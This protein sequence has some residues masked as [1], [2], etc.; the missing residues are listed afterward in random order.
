MHYRSIVFAGKNKAS[1]THI[2]SQL[3]HLIET[4]IDDLSAEIWIAQVA[5]YKIVALGF[6]IFMKFQVCTAYPKA[7]AF[8]ACR[9]M[10]TDE[11]TRPTDQGAPHKKSPTHPSH[12][13]TRSR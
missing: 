11:T 4:S 6:R 2:S 9:K 13:K 10:T 8:Q 5:N 12:D 1:S 3:V 7:I